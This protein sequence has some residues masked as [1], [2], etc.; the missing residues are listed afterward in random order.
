MEELRKKES[1]HFNTFMGNLIPIERNWGGHDVAIRMD[2]L[3][4]I[5]MQKL[6]KGTVSLEVLSED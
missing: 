1:N 5:R 6:C 4:R 2:L 3:Q